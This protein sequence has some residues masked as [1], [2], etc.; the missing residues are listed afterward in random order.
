M[1]PTTLT[2]K[3]VK[4]TPGPLSPLPQSLLNADPMASITS[5]LQARLII[6][7]KRKR[8][9]FQ[10]NFN[11]KN[12]KMPNAIAHLPQSLQLLLSQTINIGN[13]QFKKRAHS[14]HTRPH[15]SVIKS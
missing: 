3:R 6:P 1:K 2:S 8:L 11:L 5:H 13:R 14:S 15:N 10:D 9:V 4:L 7:P 12:N